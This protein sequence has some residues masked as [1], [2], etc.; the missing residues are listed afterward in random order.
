VFAEYF[1]G[2]EGESCATACQG[3]GQFC[4]PAMDLGD[5]DRGAAMMAYLN[6]STC[7]RNGTNGHTQEGLQWWAYDQVESLGLVVE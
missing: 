1:L 7:W 4:D 2:P 6:I 3:V 5:A